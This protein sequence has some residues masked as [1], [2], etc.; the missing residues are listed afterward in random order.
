M[1]NGAVTA[2]GG[3]KAVPDPRAETADAPTA[4]Y[5]SSAAEAI[6]AGHP[7]MN[8]TMRREGTRRRDGRLTK[9]CGFCDEGA[10]GVD[11]GTNA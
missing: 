6:R 8:A 2:S 10:E 4:K 3:E 7:S 11:V 1:D 5:T 9:C